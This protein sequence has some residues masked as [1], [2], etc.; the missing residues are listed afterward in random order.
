MLSQ[1]SVAGILRGIVNTQNIRGTDLISIRV[2]HTDRQD[3]AAIVNKVALNYQRS[4]P[5]KVVIHEEPSEPTYPISPKVG[6]V[7]FAGSLLGIIL[8]PFLALI[9]IMVLQRIF[10]MR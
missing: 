10:P 2:R 3:A 5:G 7:L 9:L 4:F 8:S 6:L 1:G